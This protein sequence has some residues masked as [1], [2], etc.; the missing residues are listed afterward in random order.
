MTT[1]LFTITRVALSALALG[2]IGACATTT[3]GAP[4]AAVRAADTQFQEDRQ[5]ILAM[6]GNYR[7][8]FDFTET[9]SFDAN[10]TLKDKKLSGGDEIVRVIEDTG[11]FISLQHILVVGGE[12]KFPVK[13]W[14]QDWRYEPESV[15]VFIGANAWETRK[16]APAEAKGKW[17]QV[18]YQVD[19]APR[20]GAVGAWRHENGVSAWTPPAEWRPL[21]RR[22]ATTR[23]DYH[24]IDAVNRHAITPSGW[25]HEQDNTKLVLTGKPRALVREVGVNIY[26]KFNGF[27]IAVGDDYWNATKEFWAEMRAE[28]AR[29]EAENPRFGLTIQ[30]EP[31]ELY[32]K[33][34][35]IAEAVEKNGKPVAEAAAEARA[36][37]ADYVTT[38]VGPVGERI[39]AAK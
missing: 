17:S 5:A 35:D 22:D 12:K 38:D 15:L 16:L 8:T 1:A 32:M 23:D 3:A 20:Y 4:A 36:V 2:A 31:E 10:Y 24:A 19:D 29:I 34:L 7:V 28:W 27:D 30:G 13:H 11:D 6:A 18:V 25:V 37:M 21:P 33:I 26:E 9:V 39:A 14:R